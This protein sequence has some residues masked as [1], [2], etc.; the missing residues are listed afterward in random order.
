V[1]FTFFL[2]LFGR[3]S[4]SNVDL[5]LSRLS[6]CINVESSLWKVYSSCGSRDDVATF[7]ISGMGDMSSFGLC[8]AQR[9]T[10]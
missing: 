4:G 6:Q 5:S 9:A 2:R 8:R 1:A 3:L 7:D 10:I